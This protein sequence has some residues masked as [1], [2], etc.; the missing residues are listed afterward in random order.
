[1]CAPWLFAASTLFSYASCY[2]G[3][4]LSHARYSSGSGS[5]PKQTKFFSLIE[6]ADSDAVPPYALCSATAATNDFPT[7]G[8][9]LASDT[10]KRAKI[11]F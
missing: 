8:A 11:S 5:K 3:P 1:M 6:S 4:T 10:A 2:S 7:T 9:T